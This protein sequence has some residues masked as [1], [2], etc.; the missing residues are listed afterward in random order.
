MIDEI[1][2]KSIPREDGDDD[3]DDSARHGDGPG[4]DAVVVL[5]CRNV[6]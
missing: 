6:N 4:G 2:S 1:S 5:A 3:A